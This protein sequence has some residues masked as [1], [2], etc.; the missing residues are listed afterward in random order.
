MWYKALWGSL[1]LIKRNI[2]TGHLSSSYYFYKCVI[3]GVTEAVQQ[4][5][6]RR[7]STRGLKGQCLATFRYVPG[8]T[9]RN[10]MAKLLPQ[11]VVK[12]SR[13]LLVS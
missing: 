3:G 10:Q 12:L 1:D 11:Y 13:V 2:I 5:G 4:T 9:F 8:P 6:G 7:A